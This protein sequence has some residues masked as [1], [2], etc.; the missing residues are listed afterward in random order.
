MN[1][2]TLQSKV[3]HIACTKQAWFVSSVLFGVVYL[4]RIEATTNYERIVAL[5]FCVVA[6][7]IFFF[8]GTML[9]GVGYLLLTIFAEA[10][11]L[12]FTTKSGLI[13]FVLFCMLGYLVMT[14]WI[15]D[16]EHHPVYR[17]YHQPYA[18]EP[19]VRY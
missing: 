8:I 16:K 6:P 2:Q 1:I 12:I 19:D 17:E 5:L 7:P 14:P 15:E 9:L 10:F 3:T 18:P 4:S 13:G 11:K